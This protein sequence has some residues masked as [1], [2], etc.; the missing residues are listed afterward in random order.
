MNPAF[1]PPAGFV[2]ERRVALGLALVAL[3]VL[4]ATAGSASSPSTT[5]KPRALRPTATQGSPGWTPVVD[6]ES[7]SVLLGRR[8]NAPLVKMPFSGGTRSMKEMGQLVCRMLHRRSADS[9]FALCV[10]DS[11]FRDILW[12]EFPSSRPATGLT[13]EDGW[14][15]LHS[16]LV[17]GTRDATADYGGRDYQFLRWERAA[18]TPDTLTAYKNF[19]LHNGLLLVARRD[20]GEIER[21]HWLR[22]IAERKGRFK[23]YSTND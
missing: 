1:R 11:E 13:W 19:K 22:S 23:I 7:T 10:A 5:T 12:P 3:L 15:T 4:R 2:R 14:M 21:M 20:D 9:L 6:P 18:A 17:S 8:P 16:R